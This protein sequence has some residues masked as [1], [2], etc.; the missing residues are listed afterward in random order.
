MGVRLWLQRFACTGVVLGLL[1]IG[2]YWVYHS[3]RYTRLR[4]LEAQLGE[5][6]SG[7]EAI[8]RENRGLKREILRLRHDLRAVGGVARDELGLVAPGEIVIQIEAGT[9]EQP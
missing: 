5:L 6:G 4:K 7:N 3:D 8:A 2:P 1:V 9:P